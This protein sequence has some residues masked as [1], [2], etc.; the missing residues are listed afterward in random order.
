MFREVTIKWGRRKQGMYRSR[1][2]GVHIIY[3]DDAPRLDY[4]RSPSQQGVR[5]F[6]HA[7]LYLAPSLFKA[8]W[9]RCRVSRRKDGYKI[10]KIYNTRELL[11]SIVASFKNVKSTLCC[12]MLRGSSFVNMIRPW[13]GSCPSR[14]SHRQLSNKVHVKDAYV[15]T[16]ARTARWNSKTRR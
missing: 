7:A 3:M 12:W 6:Y 1:E 16:L 11:C 10:S 4:R 14:N 5:K 15:F 2:I 13:K 8:R 9:G